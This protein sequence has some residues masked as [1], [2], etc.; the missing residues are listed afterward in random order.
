MAV[1]GLMFGAVALWRTPARECDHCPHCLLER[2]ETERRRGEERHRQV[3][4]VYGPH[5]P[6]C[7]HDS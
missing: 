4:A 3:H 7:R 6:I 1:V 5:C 2:Q